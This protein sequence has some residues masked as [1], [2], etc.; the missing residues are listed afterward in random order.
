[1]TERIDTSIIDQVKNL[2][3]IAQEMNDPYLEEALAYVV[4]LI[5]KPDIPPPVAVPTIV[6]LS[7]LANHFSFQATYYRTFGHT[8]TGEQGKAG[9]YRKDMYYTAAEATRS[10]AD[11]L[12]YIVRISEMR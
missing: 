7:A 10:L 5:S 1:L 6:K 8:G 12:K 9:R 2:R 4:K 3:N 11:S